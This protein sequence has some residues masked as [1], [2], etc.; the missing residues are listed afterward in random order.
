[1]KVK[2]L[3]ELLSQVDGESELKMS[4]NGGEYHSDM[5]FLEIEVRDGVV[6]LLD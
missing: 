4:Q 1:M 5:E 2:E 3:I 6:W